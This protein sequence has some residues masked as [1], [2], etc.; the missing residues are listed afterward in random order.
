MDMKPVSEFRSWVYN[1]WMENCEERSTVN[2]DP[3]TMEQ[4]WNTYKYWLKQQY[5]KAQNES[6][7]TGNRNS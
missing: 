7:S 5:R 3:V 2:E 6:T 4:Y 1:I